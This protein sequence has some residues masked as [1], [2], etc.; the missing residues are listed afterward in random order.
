LLKG[1]DQEKLEV[2]SALLASSQAGK[3]GI[4]EIREV[5]DII[6]KTP[7][8]CDIELDLTLARGLNYYTG[9]IIEVKALDVAMGSV[10]GGGRYDD[11]TGIFGLQGVSGVGISFG[12]D[13]I[14]DVMNELGLFPEG[15]GAFTKLL[16]VNFGERERNYCLPLLQKLRL[17]GISCEMYPEPAKMKKQMQYAD[18]NKI[19][20]VV[21]A[22]E[23]EIDQGLF[24]LKNMKTGEQQQVP[25]EELI[26]ILS[27]HIQ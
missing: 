12:A 27:S 16:A 22:G 7:T 5:F 21:L 25:A 6:S 20:F 11:L 3:K 8:A 18:R 13:R 24:S 17:R 9:A 1:S 14:Y 26:K 19:P 4:E 2:L 15:L 10:C 23:S